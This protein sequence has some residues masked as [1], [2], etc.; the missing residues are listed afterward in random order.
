LV[1][2]LSD[3]PEEHSPTADVL[4]YS[5]LTT[6]A[7]GRIVTPDVRLAEIEQRHGPDSAVASGLRAAALALAE[8][9]SRTEALIARHHLAA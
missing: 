1:E 4:T 5:D 2:L 7:E 9:V 6:D 3:Y 8:A